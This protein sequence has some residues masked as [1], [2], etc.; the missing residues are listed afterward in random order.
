MDSSLSDRPL[1]LDR[2][3]F[4]LSGA[5]VATVA[6]RASLAA[7]QPEA[8]AQRK[9]DAYSIRIAAADQFQKSSWPLTAPN[10]D[11]ARYPDR[12]ASFTKTLPHDDLGEVAPAAYEAF[13]DAMRGGTSDAFART[14]RAP[15]AVV[16]L[17][18]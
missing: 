17:N 13:V 8:V 3:A 6:G 7:P 15:G 5:L 18:N 4:L 9:S 1:A 2:R 12:R 14:P 10:G 11:E 16:R